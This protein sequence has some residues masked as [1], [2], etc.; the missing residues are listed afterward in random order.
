MNVT[1]YL[2]FGLDKEIQKEK[3]NQYAKICY[4]EYQLDSKR[5]WQR[6]RKN[7]GRVED[8]SKSSSFSRKTEQGII[9][10]LNAIVEEFDNLLTN[11]RP[12]MA[13]RKPQV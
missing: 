3:Q 6:L 8:R 2:K 7:F 9:S 13:R 5:P 11:L 4:E 10:A 1:W 12:N